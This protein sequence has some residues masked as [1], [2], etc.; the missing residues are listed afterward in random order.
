MKKI[1]VF[2]PLFL[3]L[4][5]CE[6]EILAPDIDAVRISP[7]GYYII[8]AVRVVPVDTV[9]LVPRNSQDATIIGFT[10]EFYD[11][12]D[13]LIYAAPEPFPLSV[14]VPGLVEPACDCTTYIYNLFVQTDTLSAYLLNNDLY[15]AKILYRFIAEADYFPGRYDTADIYLG[16]YRVQVI[17]IVN[18]ESDQDSIP[19]DGASS[20]RITA[21]VQDFGGNPVLGALLDF[22]TTLGTLNPPLAI[23][24]SEGQASVYLISDQGTQTATATV[25]VNHPYASWPL[26]IPVKFYIP[27]P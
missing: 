21:T 8:D 2:L 12:N 11:Y 24:N 13:N 26:A 7:L 9:V 19:R 27:Q 16:L 14:K 6:Q 4:M 5:S 3:V 10:W 17:Y 15:S 25:T 20:A 22:T 18:L 23:T 1:L